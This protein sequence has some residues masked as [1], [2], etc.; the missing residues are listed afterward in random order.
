MAFTGTQIGRVGHCRRKYEK[1]GNNKGNNSLIARL[2]LSLHN[3]CAD[4]IYGA[5]LSLLIWRNEW[6]WLAGAVRNLSWQAHDDP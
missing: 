3:D 6:R 1:N 2:H 4:K 5:S